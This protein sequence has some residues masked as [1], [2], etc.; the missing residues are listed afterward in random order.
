MCMHDRKNTEKRD[1]EGKHKFVNKSY[2]GRK[3]LEEIIN[4]SLYPLKSP[5]SQ[6][7]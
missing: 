4:L 1:R 5:K 2:F 6:T 7:T 3:K